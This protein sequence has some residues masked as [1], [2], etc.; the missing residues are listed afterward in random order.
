MSGMDLKHGIKPAES[1][2]EASFSGFLTRSE[3]SPFSKP[4]RRKAKLISTEAFLG[5]YGEI[6]WT[7]GSPSY[8]EGLP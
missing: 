2:K 3:F 7:K 1:N 8:I 4:R 6:S 5:G